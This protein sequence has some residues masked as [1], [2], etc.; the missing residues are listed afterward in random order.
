MLIARPSQSQLLHR[1]SEHDRDLSQPVYNAIKRLRSTRFY[2]SKRKLLPWIYSNIASLEFETAL[3]LFGGSASVSL[4]FK[5]MRKSVVYHDGLLFNE[6][7]G[8]PY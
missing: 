8:E 6:D 7:V 5:I 4:L 2:G 1:S 3:D